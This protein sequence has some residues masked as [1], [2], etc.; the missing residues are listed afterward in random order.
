MRRA[1]V[2]LVACLAGSACAVL[3]SSCSDERS[4][5]GGCEEDT[6]C[7]GDR[8][9]E[10]GDCV[11]PGSGSD[12]DGPFPGSSGSSSEGTTS[13]MADDGGMSTSGMSSGEDGGTSGGM[14]GG[15][16]PFPPSALDCNVACANEIVEC[17]K[18]CDGDPLCAYG[19]NAPEGKC[20]SDCEYTVHQQMDPFFVEFFGCWQ[21][22]TDCDAY[23]Q[24][25]IDSDCDGA[26]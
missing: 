6:D 15:Y 22:T 5:G 13:G 12:D 16:C 4:S 2:T 9:C 18:Q 23:T 8:I 26:M 1:L 7:K 14:T 20:V 21:L 10:D 19:P 25:V 17:E 3:A 24:C 11:E